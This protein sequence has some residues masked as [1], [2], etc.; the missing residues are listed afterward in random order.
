VLHTTVAVIAP[1]HACLYVVGMNWRSR[2]TSMT[3]EGVRHDAAHVVRQIV[4]R[5]SE[6]AGLAVAS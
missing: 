2:R 4:A 3:I 5:L 6:R 1:G